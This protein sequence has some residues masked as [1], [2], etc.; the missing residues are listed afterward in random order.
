MFTSMPTVSVSSTWAA[1]ASGSVPTDTGQ[2][3]QVL[4]PPVR[5][6]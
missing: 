6:T 1:I 4:G 5:V 2:G 3:A